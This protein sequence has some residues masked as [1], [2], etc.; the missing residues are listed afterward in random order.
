MPGICGTS[1][2]VNLVLNIGCPGVRSTKRYC[3]S[4]STF[5]ISCSKFCQANVPHESS[6]QRNPPFSRYSRIRAASSSVKY[7]DSACHNITNGHWKSASSVGR[8]INGN[9]SPSSD[10][11]TEVLVSSD[12]RV[13][14][15]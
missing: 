11:P 5:A 13:L 3:G 7:S 2:S 10:L 15:L 4:G 9:G 12:T 6:D 14:K 8:T 1:L